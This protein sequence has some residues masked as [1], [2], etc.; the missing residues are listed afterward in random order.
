MLLRMSA[1]RDRGP[2]RQ[3]CCDI[4]ALA[5]AGTVT[6]QRGT[7]SSTSSGNE[8]CQHQPPQDPLPLELHYPWG[9]PVG[10]RHIPA[11][12]G[13]GV[14][15][16]GRGRGCLSH[17]D[18]GCGSSIPGIPRWRLRCGQPGWARGQLTPAQ[19]PA[20]PAPPAQLSSAPTAQLP[21]LCHLLQIIKELP[22]CARR[23]SRLSAAWL[24]FPDFHNPQNL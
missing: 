17:G 14:V 3:R 21:Q 7:I 6:C 11:P 5:V 2:Q 16:P 1:H 4:H 13:E 22:A 10:T 12:A 8:P 23:I 9:F 15:L 24:N 19:Q 20:A 18:S